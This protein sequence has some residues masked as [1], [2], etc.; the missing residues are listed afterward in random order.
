MTF[1]KNQYKF[2]LF[3]LKHLNFLLCYLESP[4]P[5]Y[6]LILILFILGIG[7]KKEELVQQINFDDTQ[8]FAKSSSDDFTLTVLGPPRANPYSVSNMQAAYQ[9]LYNKPPTE[10][11]ATH[12]YVRYEPSDVEQIKFLDTID[13]NYYDFPL[14]HEIIEMGDYYIDPIR[15]TESPPYLYGTLPVGKVIPGITTT[16]LDTLYLY[17]E[18]EALIREAL[19]LKGYDPDIEGY[20]VGRHETFIPD[21]TVGG[22]GSGSGGGGSGSTGNIIKD[23]DCSCKS[24]LHQRNPAGCV[25][26]FDTQLSSSGNCSTYKG[27]AYVKVILK[28]TW[29]TEHTVWTNRTGCFRLPNAKFKNWMWQWIKFSHTSRGHVRGVRNGW[30]S[31]WDWASPIKKYVGA[32]K[33]TNFN[34]L[35]VCLNTSTNENSK[36]RH[37]WNAATVFN[38]LHEYYDFCS[39]NQIG[40]PPKKLDMYIDRNDSGGVAYMFDKMT[41]KGP[42]WNNI[43]LG[44]SIFSYCS[45]GGFGRRFLCHFLSLYSIIPIASQIVSFMPDVVVGCGNYRNTVRSSDR[46]KTTVYHELGHAAHYQALPSNSRNYWWIGNVHYIAHIGSQANPYGD[47]THSG[48][49]KCAVIEMWGYHI[50]HTIADA[51]YGL[52][53][54]G[55]I[56]IQPGE[57]KYNNSGRSSHWWALEDY[58]PTLT[59]DPTRW[60]PLGVLH[61]LMDDRVESTPVSDNVSGFNNSQI[62]NALQS[63]VT[64][65]PQYRVRF[66]QQNSNNQSVAVNTLFSS[67]GY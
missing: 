23:Q 38:G 67:Y 60:M 49:P 40:N 24:G 7:C 44:G 30:G 6:F 9:S 65:I 17:S 57:W 4:P 2:D 63:D 29:F 43:M 52:Q 22:G 42:I 18:D 53:S 10:I 35:D 21:D 48:A 19:S 50:G 64:S 32:F 11:N 13:I 31:L 58:N 41:D 59:T 51:A 3:K 45:G 28:D 34:N 61:D 37:Y 56:R 27:V 15:G 20:A 33:L 54:S 25:S 66:L 47:G 8:I 16:I 12:Y 14:H 55:E 5:Q 1:Y 36:D 26:V 46:I 62:F 39:L